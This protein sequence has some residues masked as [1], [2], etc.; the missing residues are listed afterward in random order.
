MQKDVINQSNMFV[1]FLKS[2]PL[3][4]IRALEKEIGASV[5]II[6]HPMSNNAVRDIPTKYWYQLYLILTHYG[7]EYP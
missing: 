6:G 1:Q 7:F 2:H 3:I 4:S 5:G